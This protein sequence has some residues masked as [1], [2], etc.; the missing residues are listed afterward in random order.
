MPIF[1]HMFWR[2][3][4]PNSSANRMLFSAARPGLEGG[5]A[6]AIPPDNLGFG[7]FYCSLPACSPMPVALRPI[8]NGI[9]L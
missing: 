3:M 4:C 8:A 2:G 5:T 1:Y 9:L 6:E 7:K